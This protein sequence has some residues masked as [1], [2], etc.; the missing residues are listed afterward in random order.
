M[1]DQ[2]DGGIAWTEQTWNP[3]RGCSR[4]SEGCRNCYAETMAA[5]FSGPGQPYEGLAKATPSGPR[6]TGKARVVE[7]HLADPLRWTRPRMVF[8]NSMSDLFHEALTNE[9][10]A[11]VFGVMAAA[12]RHTFQVL[13]KRAKRMREWFAWLAAEG[14]GGADTAICVEAARQATRDVL[15]PRLVPLAP[16]ETPAVLAKGWTAAWPL[17]NVWLGVSIEDQA[18]ADERVPQLVD[19]PAAVQW[20]SYEPALGPVDFAPWLG[21]LGDLGS[22]TGFGERLDWIVIGGESGPGARPFD[23]EWAR[24]TIAAGKASGVPVFVKQLGAVP[25]EGDGKHTHIAGY[26]GGPVVCDQGYP[27][28]ICGKNNVQW[29]AMT[30][31]DRKGGDPAEWPEGLRVREWPKAQVAS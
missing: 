12:S 5:R 23:L 3:I 15:G 14:R 9:Q 13:T 6:W 25:F 29:I 1:S 21:E 16:F 2:R 4:V 27:C 20:V 18:S 22:W 8:V 28:P 10:I 11:A 31:A 26:R 30:I 19:T 24:S 17:P 7:D